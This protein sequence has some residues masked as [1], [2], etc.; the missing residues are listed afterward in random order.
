MWTTIVLLT[1]LGGTPGQT[2]LALTHV[3]STHGL[4]GP[5]RQNETL[6]PGDILFVSYDIEGIKVDGDGKVNY[7]TAMELADSGGRVVFRQNPK[8]SQAQI[9]LGGDSA[10]G[11]ASLSVGLDTP[12]GDYQFKVT[13]KDMASGKEQSLTRSLKVLPRDFA[14][15]RATASL[16]TEAQY[17]AGVYVCGQGVWVHCSAVGFE[18]DRTGGQPNVVYEVRV[19]DESGKATLP[20]AVTNTVK[21]DVPANVSGLQMA[22]PLSLNRAG[23]FTVELSAADQISGKKAKTSFPITVQKQ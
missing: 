14:L 9:S 2:D 19:L 3:R 21:K 13:V 23:K 15:V 6:A 1:A 11:Y 16:D 7:S 20:K 12:A 18:R 17:P 5:E 4:L 8:P 10:P 22:F